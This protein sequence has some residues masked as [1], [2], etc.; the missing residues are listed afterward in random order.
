[1][2]YLPRMPQEESACVKS[3]KSASIMA[4]GFKILYLN[5][6]WMRRSAVNSSKNCYQTKVEHFGVN[7]GYDAAGVLM[8]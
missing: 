4:K 2:M 1:M 6:F 5:A 3:Q 7:A 8:V